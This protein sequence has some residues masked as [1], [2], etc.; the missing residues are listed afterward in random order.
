MK[1][2]G[3]DL[4]QHVIPLKTLSLKAG[5]SLSVRISHD[6]SAFTLQGVSDVG[7]KVTRQ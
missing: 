4:R 1:G 7:L 2:R 5:D 6:M 3:V